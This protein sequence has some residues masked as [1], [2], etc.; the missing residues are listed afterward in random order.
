MMH[1]NRTERWQQGLKRGSNGNQL[2]A[3]LNHGKVRPLWLTVVFLIQ[4]IC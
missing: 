2:D 3:R 4:I 1:E